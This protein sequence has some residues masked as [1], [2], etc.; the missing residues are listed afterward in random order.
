MFEFPESATVYGYPDWTWFWTD[1]S[2]EG[3]A[4]RIDTFKD[5]LEGLDELQE[6][7]LSV[8]DRLNCEIL[9]YSLEDTLEGT[10]FKPEYLQINQ[11][12]GIHLSI[13]M[14]L[15]IMPTNTY[16]DYVDIRMRMEDVPELVEQ[17]IDLLKKGLATGITPPK[18][19]LASVPETI[20]GLMTPNPK[21]SQ[22]FLPFTLF[23]SSFDDWDRKYEQRRAEAS[24][25]NDIYPAMQQ[26]HDFLVNEYIPNCRETIAMKDMPDG[27]AWYRYV[28][29]SFTTTDMTPEQIHSLGLSEVD[30]IKEGMQNILAE[31]NFQG[32]LNDFF[33][34][35]RTDPQFFFDRPED[36]LQGY[37]DILNVVSENLSSQFGKLPNLPFEVVPIPA[38]SQGASVAAYYLPGSPK[39]GRPGQFFANTFNLK[40]RPKWEMQALALHEAVPGHHLQTSIASEM[41][42]SPNSVS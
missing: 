24:I 37:R 38:H 35:L 21:D 4:D 8:D 28:V 7:P 15:N 12:D 13:G 25:I 11:M 5:Y 14:I 20:R 36:L 9:R 30:R 32:S 31:V 1:M 39:T 26:L 23:P 2:A 19:M 40:A 27:E 22:F 16:S 17:T 41:E 3:I 29:K 33:H 42:K 18:D 10:R 6:L 34:Y